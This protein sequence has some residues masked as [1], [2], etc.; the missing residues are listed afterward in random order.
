[1]NTCAGQAATVIVFKQL[2][3]S[4]LLVFNTT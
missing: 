4:Q 1:V 2:T 3:F